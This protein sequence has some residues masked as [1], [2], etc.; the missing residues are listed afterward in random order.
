MGK[1]PDPASTP[2]S[3]EKATVASNYALKSKHEHTKA[4]KNFQACFHRFIFYFDGLSQDSIHLA[5]QQIRHLGG[6]VEPFFSAKVTHVIVPDSLAALLDEPETPPAETPNPPT[7]AAG[8]SKNCLTPLKATAAYARPAT[9]TETCSAT[10]AIRTTNA[11]VDI[12][13]MARRWQKKVWTLGK[14]VHRVLRNLPGYRKEPT[15][16]ETAQRR[17]VDALQEERVFGVSRNLHCQPS[18]TTSVANSALQSVALES[19]KGRTDVYYFKR[20]YILVEDV[21]NVHRP[22]MVGEYDLP[23]ENAPSPWPRLYMVP[24]GR[25]PFVQYDDP[26]YHAS[27]ATAFTAKA[28]QSASTA[29]LN[30][31]ALATLPGPSGTPTPTKSITPQVSVSTTVQMCP[32]STTQGQLLP[33][34][35]ASGLT[36]ESAASVGRYSFSSAAISFDPS[37]LANLDNSSRLLLLQSLN[38]QLSQAG[39]TRFLSSRGPESR[40]TPT[41]GSDLATMGVVAQLASYQSVKQLSKRAVPASL[42]PSIA[43]Q[44][45]GEPVVSQG[46]QALSGTATGSIP[47]ATT[48]APPSN[49][50]PLVR[51]PSTVVPNARPSQVKTQQKRHRIQRR[52]KLTP[53]AMAKAHAA[54]AKRPGFCENCRVKYDHLFDHMASTVHKQ[55]AQNE[56]NYQ[57]LDALL[58]TIPRP[59][60]PVG[61]MTPPL[62]MASAQLLPSRVASSPVLSI[63]RS[64]PL[65]SRSFSPNPLVP[66][67][68]THDSD[69]TSNAG[70]LK[71]PAPSDS[72]VVTPFPLAS[73]GLR[74]RDGPKMS[75]ASS[76]PWRALPLPVAAPSKPHQQSLGPSGHILSEGGPSDI[77]ASLANRVW[78]PST[79]SN[80]SPIISPSLVYQRL[81]AGQNGSLGASEMGDAMPPGSKR[82]AETDAHGPPA[83][84]SCPMPPF[85]NPTTQTL[86]N[87]SG[88]TLA[89]SAQPPRAVVCSMAG[90]GPALSNLVGITRESDHLVPPTSARVD[91]R[92]VC[93]PASQSPQVHPSHMLLGRSTVSM[94]PSSGPT[95]LAQTTMP[96]ST[97][98][99]WSQGFTMPAPNVGLYSTAPV[100]PIAS[101]MALASSIP[102]TSLAYAIGYPTG[103]IPAANPMTLAAFN[104]PGL[105]AGSP[106][107]PPGSHHPAEVA[108]MQ[109]GYPVNNAYT[110]YQ[111][112]TPVSSRIGGTYEMASM[113]LDSTASPMVQREFLPA[114]TPTKMFQTPTGKTPSRIET[115]LMTPQR[116]FLTDLYAQSPFTTGSP[117]P[118]QMSSQYPMASHQ[119]T[120]HLFT[121]Q[122]SLIPMSYRIP[123]PNWPQVPNPMNPAPPNG[124]GPE[125]PSPLQSHHWPHR[126]VCASAEAN[127][128]DTT[129]TATDCT[130]EYLMSAAAINTGPVAPTLEDAG[131]CTTTPSPPDPFLPSAPLATKGTGA[132]FAMTMAHQPLMNN[133]TVQ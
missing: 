119:I 66:L 39:S 57:E 133:E 35:L 8:G 127:P 129:S 33:P 19:G 88:C 49:V 130:N 10:S 90:S 71:R 15:R 20:I 108:S 124:L 114:A 81:V 68:T 84:R 25:C 101:T 112:I 121:P 1:P 43:K 11:K 28:A 89:L 31:L 32:T 14:L 69:V 50:A 102:S 74:L 61:L 56:A 75:S 131:L 113:V 21:T 16:A 7:D 54:P 27:L 46:H 58:H 77:R 78:H 104:Y 91:L 117:L 64:L 2:R 87:P 100:S 132:Q 45:R 3:H 60:K 95:G 59:R 30:R 80:P 42:L 47:P 40:R 37:M 116:Q 106:L 62:T 83:K 9:E 107:R 111:P 17:L 92:Q 126:P 41:A 73:L 51:L 48:R 97:L 109:G 70:S 12:I 55:F 79:G 110:Q 115:A 93:A 29:N 24:A 85:V 72:L 22:I 105:W 53:K 26:A 67:S 94:A 65:H 82:V 76:D 34:S 86:S 128:F 38:S 52:S 36:A 96:R 63:A 23:K 125:P 118:Q 99:S 122:P 103:M 123:P 4:L 6:T 44:L 120:P 18:I 5:V 98:G 13:H